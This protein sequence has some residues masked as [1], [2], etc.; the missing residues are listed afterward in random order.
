M[1]AAYSQPLKLDTQDCPFSLDIVN[2]FVVTYSVYFFIFLS[3]VL[4][5]PTST[6]QLDSWRSLKTTHP[7]R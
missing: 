7:I 5:A 1:P 2:A 3:K 6:L 4:L